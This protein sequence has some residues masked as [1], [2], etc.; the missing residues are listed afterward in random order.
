M[1]SMAL[2]RSALAILALVGV[3]MAAGAQSVSDSAQ[4]SPAAGSGVELESVTVEAKRRRERIDRQVSE[5]VYTIAGSGKVESL[6]RWKVPVCAVVVGLT[7]A[8]ADFVEKRIAEI[9]ADAEVPLGRPGCGPNFVVVVTPEPE[10]FLKAWWSEDHQLFNRDRGAR[11]IDR[12]IETDQP[13]RAWHN[14]CNAPP[15]VS[16]DSFSAGIHCGT[17]TIGSRLTWGVVRAIYTAIVAVDLTRIEG[18]TFGQV[19]DYV[20]MVGL[21]QI[22]SGP[23]LGEVP[24]ILRLFA[25]DNTGRPKGLTEWDQ[26]F[27]E[28]VYDTTDGSVTEISQIKLRMTDR[29][30][31]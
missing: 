19:A 12:F 5:F 20:A 31:R 11:G 15:G 13:V 22:R 21:A 30:A 26:S 14:A 3:S 7:A 1:G 24:S 6:A 17:G 23:D 2:L 28:A 29:L 10:K 4:P 16:G 8:E 9:A 18:L 27:L 25:T